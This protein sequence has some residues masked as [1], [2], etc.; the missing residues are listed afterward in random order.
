MSAFSCLLIGDKFLLIQC[1]EIL[2]GRGHRIVAVVTHN[3]Q[4]RAWAAGHDL[5]I[6]APDKTLAARLES[7]SF[8][9]LF[10]IA[11]LEVIPTMLAYDFP[12]KGN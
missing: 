4:V 8:D 7:V 2:R 6:S 9:W 12:E 10:A 1:G 11:N 3:P 5:R